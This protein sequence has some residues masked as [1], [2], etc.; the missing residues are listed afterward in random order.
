MTLVP[1]GEDGWPLRA[2]VEAAWRSVITGE[3]TRESVHNWSV[4]WVEGHRAVGPPGDLMV[5]TGL[6]Y[7]HGLDM[8]ADPVRLDLTAHGGGARYVLS[9]DEVSARFAHWLALCS[10]YDEDPEGFRQRAQERAR[11]GP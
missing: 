2:S 10:E 3:R 8:A 7:L 1:L 11:H 9:D 6:Q 5:G 4:P